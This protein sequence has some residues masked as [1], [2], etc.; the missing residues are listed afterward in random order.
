ME[1]K[2]LSIVVPTK[3]RYYY[4]KYLIRLVDNLH[5][6]EVELVIQD[7]SDYNN[8]FVEYL[9]KKSF[10][11]IRYSYIQGQIPMSVNTDKAIMNSTGEYICFLGDDDG[12]TK[13]LLDGVH[14]M[15]ENGVEAVKPA[16]PLYS[17]PDAPQGKSA[18]ISYHQFTGRV[19]FVSAYDELLKVLNSGILNRGRMPIAYHAV[20]SRE[21]LDK[22]YDIA[23]TYFPG[24]SP[25]IS[26]AVALSLVVKKFALVNIPWAYS[27]NSAYKG[28]GVFA[29]GNSAPRITEIKWF[30]PNPEKNWYFKVPKIASGSNI[31][32]DSAISSLISMQRE[33]MLNEINFNELYANFIFDFPQ[34]KRL[35]FDICNSRTQISIYSFYVKLRRFAFAAYRRLGWKLHFLPKRK[36]IKNIENI[37]QASNKLEELSDGKMIFH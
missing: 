1:R 28:G 11:F 25:D 27:G 5:S 7:N 23:G 4:L 15:K 26:N 30:R 19:M 6:E 17:W 37:I 14:W 35:V 10:S 24:N 2:L 8:E 29:Q 32:A 20:V 33:D 9:K 13:Y 34:H 3:N 36:V 12:F 21:V 16:E 22:V 18:E 31:W